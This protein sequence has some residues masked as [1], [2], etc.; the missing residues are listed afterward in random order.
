MG[1]GFE[2]SVYYHTHITLHRLLY[3]FTHAAVMIIE[4]PWWF[5]GSIFV[6]LHFQWQYY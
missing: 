5:C 1:L 4:Y 2:R 6:F 3:K